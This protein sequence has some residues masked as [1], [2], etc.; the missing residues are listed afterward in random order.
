MLLVLSDLIR[1]ELSRVLTTRELK[2][3]LSNLARAHYEGK[4]I[5]SA[6]AALLGRLGDARE[7]SEDTRGI[8]KQIKLPTCARGPERARVSASPGVARQRPG[9]TF[10]PLRSIL[11]FSR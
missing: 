10:W 8:W 1:A 3:A 2:D 9:F 7:L 6:S 11:N 5:V 4:H